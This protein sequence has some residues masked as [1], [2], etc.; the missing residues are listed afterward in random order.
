M[1][2]Q[3]KDMFNHA[4]Y[5]TLASELATLSPAFNSSVFLSHTLDGLSSRELMD[6][7]RRTSTGIA[8]ALPLSYREQLAV[9]HELAPR[10]GH[11]FIGIFLSDF[12]AQYG[13][14]DVDASLNAL[15]FFT[16]FGS[17]EF[18]I[19][20]FL[21]RDLPGTLAVM[22]DWAR[23]DDEHVRRL[24]SE[25]S[26]PR[27]P[28]GA[29]LQSLV[30]DPSPTLPILSSLRADP[31]LYVRKSVANH[32]NDICKDHP[33]IVLDLVS[34]WDRSSPPTA[35]IIR[36]ALRTLIK[37][38]HPRA[39]ALLGAGA[40]PKLDVTFTIR[41]AR[42]R[43]GD[44]VALAATLVSTGLR[45]PQALMVD[46]IVHYPRASGISSKKVFK[47]KQ[48]TLPAGEVVTLIKRQTIRDFSTR[49][50][51]PGKH[52]VELQINGRRLAEAV[53]ILSV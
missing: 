53:F 21:A 44:T 47:W 24:A 52:R 9:L 50:H 23:S 45:R 2:S 27:L 34:T 7:M 39:L 12:V 48:L 15:R 41:P 16:R 51:H 31:S 10:I 26:R 43:L 19:R 11:N 30:A 33:D 32:L 1:S 42:I 38:G 13:L 17:A 4:R 28:W 3:L 8:A 37:R 29:R 5:R 25:G 18:A 20:P 40:A 6:R 49:R 46:Y 22:T 35:W 14:N 36:H